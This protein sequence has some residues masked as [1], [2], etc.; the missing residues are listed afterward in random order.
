ME[1]GIEVCP[2]HFVPIARRH[3][4]EQRIAVMAGIIHENIDSPVRAVDGLQRG[5]PLARLSDIEF[6]AAA[7]IWKFRD[8]FVR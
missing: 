4:R 8:E 7:A 2:E 5:L 1:N 3:R 6:D